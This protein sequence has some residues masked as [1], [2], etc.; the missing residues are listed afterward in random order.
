MTE[1]QFNKTSVMMQH[2]N[3]YF[4]QL[5]NFFPSYTFIIIPFSSPLFISFNLSLFFHLF[6]FLSKWIERIFSSEEYA[7][8]VFDMVHRFFC[9]SWKFSLSYSN[10]FSL[11]TRGLLLLW[12]TCPSCREIKWIIWWKSNER[13]LHTTT[14]HLPSI[15]TTFLLYFILSPLFLYFF[16]SFLILYSIYLYVY[17][18]VHSCTIFSSFLS[19]IYIFPN[20]LL[21]FILFSLFILFIFHFIFL[22]VLLFFFFTDFSSTVSLMSLQRRNFLRANLFL[23]L[24]V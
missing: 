13:R 16:F 2:C 23:T 10:T 19:Y 11:Y 18:C 7:K 21:I 15:P 20:V 4:F 6:I 24:Y 12:P 1:K 14:N 17:M 5:S 8:L 3:L 9:F 22:L